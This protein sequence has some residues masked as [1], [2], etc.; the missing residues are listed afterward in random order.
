[1]CCSS[2]FFPWVC[3]QQ[4]GRPTSWRAAL[5]S[6]Y[7]PQLPLRLHYSKIRAGAPSV[8]PPLSC[9]TSS[10]SKQTSPLGSSVNKANPSLMVQELRR[11]LCLTTIQS[12]GGTKRR[13][14]RLT[15]SI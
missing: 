4:K 5:H 15:S 12:N 8:R 14:Q 10:I 3:S 1:M 13:A 9:F 11:Y 7:K 2:S 6:C